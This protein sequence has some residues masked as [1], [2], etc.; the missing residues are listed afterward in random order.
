MVWWSR[1]R[2]H[3]ALLEGVSMTALLIYLGISVVVSLAVGWFIREA[4]E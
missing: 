3:W 1:S 2:L 4:G